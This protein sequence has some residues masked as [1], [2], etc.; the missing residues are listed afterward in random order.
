MPYAKHS[1]SNKKSSIQ[2]N[3]KL[4]KEAMDPDTEMNPSFKKQVLAATQMKGPYKMYGKEVDPRTME[5]SG[6]LAKY[7]CTR[8]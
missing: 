5:G 7:G 6:V 4:K 1:T 3:D 8:K 2:F